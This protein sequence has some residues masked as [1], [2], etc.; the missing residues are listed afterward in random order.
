M[1][2]TIFILFLFARVIV[3]YSQ[4]SSVDTLKSLNASKRFYI[5]TDIFSP[6]FALVTNRY[7]DR[8][9]SLYNV[10]VGYMF[11]NS[12]NK[13]VKKSVQLTF[14]SYSETI[15]SNSFYNYP[16]KDIFIKRTDFFITPE[17][18]FLYNKKRVNKGFYMSLGIGGGVHNHYEDHSLLVKQYAWNGLGAIGYL[19]PIKRFY[20]DIKLGY[21]SYFSFRKDFYNVN[22]YGSSP[23]EYVDDAN[24][25]N[26]NTNVK[27][28]ELTKGTIVSYRY[29]YLGISAPSEIPDLGIHLGFTF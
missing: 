28:I 16:T 10:C 25:Y 3:S 5:Q 13:K 17:F 22:F 26:I 27:K 29:K 1:K 20:I 6:V 23:Q 24:K 4:H 18:K 11:E 21:G 12:I 8:Q 14:F 9:A 2:K 7:W 15:Y 19:I